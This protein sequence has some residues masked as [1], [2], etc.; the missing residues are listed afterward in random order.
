[1]SS[2]IDIITADISIF[3]DLTIFVM[4]FSKKLK[5]KRFFELE[6]NVILWHH[7][8]CCDAIIEPSCQHSGNAVNIKVEIHIT[9]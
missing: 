4:S 6:M 9:M 1:M 7:S 5:V 2:N 3:E 8:L